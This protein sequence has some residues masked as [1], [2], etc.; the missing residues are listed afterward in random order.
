MHQTHVSHN[1]RKRIKKLKFTF[2][3]N[4]YQIVVRLVLKT[5]LKNNN[6]KIIKSNI[7][8]ILIFTKKCLYIFRKKNVFQPLKSQLFFH[9]IRNRYLNLNTFN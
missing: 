5:A 6:N 2:L 4:L 3:N 8:R 1:L 9:R 7:R